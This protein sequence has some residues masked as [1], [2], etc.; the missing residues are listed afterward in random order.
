MLQI[1]RQCECFF[2]LPFIMEII[3]FELTKFIFQYIRRM[4][5]RQLFVNFNFYETFKTISSTNL[6]YLKKMRAVAFFERNLRE[7]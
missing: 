6:N 4:Q 2:V 7:N 5:K 1:S 3:H